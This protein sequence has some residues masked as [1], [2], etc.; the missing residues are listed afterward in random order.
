MLNTRRVTLQQLILFFSSESRSL[1][2][3]AIYSQASPEL[4]TQRLEAGKVTGCGPSV[5]TLTVETIKETPTI[6]GQIGP[7]PF[8]QAMAAHPDF[9]V[10]IA[11][12]AYDP[13]PYV[14]FCAFH[15]FR[16]S[17]GSFLT[18]DPTILGGFTHMGK[19][20]ECGGLCATP[21]SAASMATTFRDGSFEIRALSDDSRCTPQSVAAHALYEH[22]RP[23]ILYGP[24]GG[25]DLISAT[26]EQLA[27][28]VTVR[29]RGAIF[30]SSREDGRPYTIKFEGARMVGY[31]TIFMGSFCDPILIGQLPKLLKA[32]KAYVAQK[33]SRLQDTCSLDFHIYGFD[34]KAQQQGTQGEVF[35]VGE[36]LAATQELATSMASTARV[37]CVHGPYK[38]QKATGG[39]FGMGIGGQGEIETGP[40]AEFTIY[41]IV[42]LEDGEEEA[43]SLEQKSNGSENNNSK[44]TK[45]FITWETRLIGDGPRIDHSQPRKLKPTKENANGTTQQATIPPAIPPPV[46]LDAPCTLADI[47]QVV[48]SKTAGPFE[49]TLDVIFDNVS[50]Y[51]QVKQLKILTPQRI[52]ELYDIAVE[53]IVWC[54]F[55]D[56]ALAFKATIP[57]RRNGQAKSAGGY[58]ENDVHGSQKH[59]PLL[60][61]HIDPQASKEAS[62]S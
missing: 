56:G 18:L 46:S 54:G 49:I 16:Q 4:L 38:G 45:G 25:L 19:T 6:V 48:R 62:E 53:D 47:A 34:E 50:I 55:F 30:K 15:A 43:T 29:C 3:I 11:G 12:R 17:Y 27:D 28:G 60:N 58:M 7:E 39:N 41:H 59:L 20:M 52:A 33:H 40:C 13:S 57:R 36:A 32:V 10:V 1:K 2:V 51:E 42:D 22:S 24:G 5:P 8:V 61:L 26:Y 35:I 44:G 23:D 9:D 37:G 14:A 21:K 31:R